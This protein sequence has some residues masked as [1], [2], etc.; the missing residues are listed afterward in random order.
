M[1]VRSTA[2]RQRRLQSAELNELRTCAPRVRR[3]HLSAKQL[4]TPQHFESPRA[5]RPARV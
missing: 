3:R 5:A 2:T 4:I 1:T